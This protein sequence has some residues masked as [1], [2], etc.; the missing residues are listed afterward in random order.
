VNKSNQGM[1]IS[2]KQKRRRNQLTGFDQAFQ[3]LYTGDF[4]MRGNQAFGQCYADHQD[5][6]SGLA[7]STPTILMVTHNI[8]Q[9]A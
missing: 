1:N 7:A 9:E 6:I 3:R 8:Y 4:R 5:Q 2:I